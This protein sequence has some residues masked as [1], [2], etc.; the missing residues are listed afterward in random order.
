MCLYPRDWKGS[1]LFPFLGK[2]CLAL[3]CFGV[4]VMN[5]GLG[6]FGRTGWGDSSPG[7]TVCHKTRDTRGT[8]VTCFRDFPLQRADVHLLGFCWFMALSFLPPEHRLTLLW[9]DILLQWYIVWNLQQNNEYFCFVLNAQ[10]YSVPAQQLLRNLRLR[11]QLLYRG[12]NVAPLTS[13]L[14]A[15]S[16]ILSQAHISISQLRLIRRTK[17]DEMHEDI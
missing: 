5:F 1:K 6:A 7:M 9:S 11:S 13:A 15:C 10:C 4:F 8:L 16:W 2:N 17:W 14:Q 12:T 3:L